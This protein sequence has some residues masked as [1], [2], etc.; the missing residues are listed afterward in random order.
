M[1]YYHPEQFQISS[2]PKIAPGPK[3]K[4]LSLRFSGWP[5]FR[6]CNDPFDLGK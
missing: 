4:P 6:S 3:S 2:G 1:S 5:L